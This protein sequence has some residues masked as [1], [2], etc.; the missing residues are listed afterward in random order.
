MFTHQ[1]TGIARIGTVDADRAEPSE[2]S[3]QSEIS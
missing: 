2:R 3:E 1:D